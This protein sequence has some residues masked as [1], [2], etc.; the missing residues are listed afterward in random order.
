MLLRVRL[1]LVAV[2]EEKKSRIA[3]MV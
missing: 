1:L 2:T 3:S